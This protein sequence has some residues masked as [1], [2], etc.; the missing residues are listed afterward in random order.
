M[1]FRLP[2]R[3]PTVLASVLA[4]GLVLIVASCSHVTP[5]GP[6]PPQPTQLGSPFTLGAMS[7]QSPTLAGRCPAGSV[8]LS[9]DPG[10]C[11]RQ[12][13]LPAGFT[14]AAISPVSASPPC[15]DS[16]SRCPPP[17]CRG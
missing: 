10:Q 5:L 8:T 6:T 17:A 12:R 3:P 14:S 9:G 7:L 16:R 2:P 1:P 11:S 15:T 4:A 13:G